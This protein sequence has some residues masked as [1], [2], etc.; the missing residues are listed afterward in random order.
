M[1]KHLNSRM[2]QSTLHRAIQKSISSRTHIAYSSALILGLGMTGNAL[3]VP[4]DNNPLATSQSVISKAYTHEKT[5][6]IIDNQL[7]DAA[8][9]AASAPKNSHIYY[10]DTARDGI[11]Q[12]SQI[13][14]KHKNVTSVHLM[15]HGG[16]GYLA[17]GST[18][19]KA[20]SLAYYKQQITS[21]SQSLTSGADLMVYGCDTAAGTQGAELINQLASLTGADVAGSID[22]TGS[23][24]KGG[25]WD[26]EYR[27]GGITASTL[28]AKN[29]PHVMDFIVGD[30]SGG[31]GGGGGYDSTNG[32]GGNG[33]AGGGDNDT[34]TGTAYADVIFGDGSGGGGGSSSYGTEGAGGLGGGGADT[35]NGGAGD[36]IL[37]GDGFNGA[38]ADYTANSGA[39]DSSGGNGGLGGGGG[40]GGADYNAG[41]SGT[42]YLTGGKGGIGA[43]GGGGGDYGYGADGGIGGGGGGGGGSTQDDNSYG[44]L[45][46]GLGA[47]DGTSTSDDAGGGGGGG[48]YFGTGGVGSV[49]SDTQF[50]G[51]G[52]NGGG[53]STGTGNGGDGCDGA[54]DGNAGDYSGGSGGGGFGNADGGGSGCDDA[55]VNDPTTGANPA[56]AHGAAGGDGD[57]NVYTM[58]DPTGV[59][60]ASLMSNLVTLLTDN[61]NYGAG[62][63][64]LDGGPGSDHLFGLGGSDRFLTELD[65]ATSGGDTDTIWDLG[66]GDIIVATSAGTSLDEATIT[67]ALGA[68]MASPGANDRTVILSDGTNSVT[69]IAMAIGRDLVIGD[70]D[71]TVTAPVTPPVTPPATPPAASDS[72]GVLGMGLWSLLIGFGLGLGRLFSTRKR[73]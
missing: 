4:A 17:L 35:I 70:F 68:Q 71:T 61:P 8:T 58:P 34:L 43:G 36:D 28:I 33:G 27:V 38:D 39:G 51:T 30:G 55:A 6:V 9:L 63:D 45:G 52:G 16:P 67:A 13:L 37:F 5:L 18:I 60:N 2:R 26:L 72:D 47:T 41:S 23:I 48:G 10:L 11:E 19:L 66:T 73:D 15:S 29:Y 22:P 1:N 56:A 54:P 46:G 3:A 42:V 69:V 62:D 24:A 12:I 25:D 20:E 7:D 65:D 59:V 50:A 57:T 53:S 14:S 32:Q 31:G 49:Y 44:G 21:W 64:V 40:G